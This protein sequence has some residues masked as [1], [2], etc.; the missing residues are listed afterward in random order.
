MLSTPPVGFTYVADF[1]NPDEQR[2]LLER[3]LCLDYHHDRFRGQPLKRAYAQYGYA[4]VSSGRKLVPAPALTSFLTALI[5]K[6]LPYC[7]PEARRAQLRFRRDPTT[8][9]EQAEQL[10]L[11]P[12]LPA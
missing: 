2:A 8:Y 12:I 9:L 7:P 1:L 6:G 3:L 10:L 4:Y 5:E 11:R